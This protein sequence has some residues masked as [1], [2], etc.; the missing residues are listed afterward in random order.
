M[1]AKGVE[2]NQSK[3]HYNESSAKVK[4]VL[5]LASTVH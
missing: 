3:N 2:M 4:H 1:R 5:D